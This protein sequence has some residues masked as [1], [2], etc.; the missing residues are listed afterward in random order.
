MNRLLFTLLSFLGICLFSQSTF[1]CTTFC[2]NTG[3]RTIVG[4]NFDFIEGNGFIFINKQGI[5]KTALESHQKHLSPLKWT[6]NYG[7]ITFNWWGREFPY[8]G[9]NEVGLVISSLG[10]RPTEYPPA[11]S[12][13][14]I[15]SSQWAQYCLDSFKTVKEVIKNISGITVIPPLGTLGK[16][17][18]FICDK[19]GDCAV[20][21]YLNGRII[22]YTQKDLP[23]KVLT[24][25]EYAKSLKCL[26][27]GIIPAPDHIASI[28]RFVRTA[29]ALQTQT[30][31]KKGLS[32]EHA[33]DTLEL[34]RMGEI[35]EVDGE[36]I[37]SYLATEWSIVF[38]IDNLKVYYKTFDNKKIRHFNL[39][40]LDFSCKTQV[41]VLDIRQNTSGDVSKVF[42]DYKNE[43]NNNFINKSRSI[44]PRLSRDPEKTLKM[45]MNYPET[46][47]C[48]NPR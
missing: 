11:N 34:T 32:I 28:D 4:T 6:S 10:L 42:I 30:S 44:I 45:I 22:C 40:S 17:H 21:E 39:S 46:T 37:R 35:T 48:T 43:L 19:T 5:S 20:I 36:Q 41:K 15:V 16:L 14:A 13:A 26:R 2:L 3:S 12:K 31:E 24:N 8:T 7:N 25:T 18:Y 33:F 27:S 23:I 1:A 9:I 47:A 38:D 29:K